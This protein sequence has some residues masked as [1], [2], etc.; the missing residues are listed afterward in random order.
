MS[1]FTKGKWELNDIRPWEVWVG[2]DIHIADVHGNQEVRRANAN[3]I[4]AAPD[5]L[6]ACK[7]MLGAMTCDELNNGRVFNDDL[8]KEVKNE[9]IA[10]IAKAKA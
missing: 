5:L 10:A 7:R 3:L 4:S 8:R 9:A 2:A 6:T 1:E